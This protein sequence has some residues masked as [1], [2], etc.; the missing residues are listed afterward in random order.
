MMHFANGK[1]GRIAT[2]YALLTA[3]GGCG[4]GQQDA[5]QSTAEP[6][7]KTVEAAAASDSHSLRLPMRAEAGRLVR[8]HA[9]ATGMV[10]ERRV[11]LGDAVVA[12]QVL[13][14]IRAPEVDQAARGAEAEQQL[15]R[16]NLKLARTH[17]L[18]ARRLIESNAISRELYDEREGAFEV[19]QANLASA[20]ARLSNLREQQG[21]QSIRAPIAGVITTRNIEQGDRVIADQGAAATPLF[22]LSTLDPLRVIVD[23]PQD[24]LPQIA[25]GDRAQIMFSG[26]DEAG[27]DATITRL[28]Q[29]VSPSTGAMRVELDLP[30]PDR[31]FRPGMTGQVLFTLDRPQSVALIPI[32]SLVQNGTQ[33]QVIRVS[34]AGTLDFR[35]VRLGRNL[36]NQ[37]EITEGIAAGD[38]IVITPNARLRPKDKVRARASD[39]GGA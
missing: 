32:S 37:V 1:W 31:R 20:T 6:E 22:E 26:F 25:E 12:G 2:L 21:F 8:I 16:A 15:A 33:A 4:N 28:G 39:D 30:N 34:E 14:V 23:I 36:G 19:A 3:L 7:V 9:R 27:R 5:A 11:D 17:Y 10:A 18:R 38:R 35:T 24:A 29:R 13:A